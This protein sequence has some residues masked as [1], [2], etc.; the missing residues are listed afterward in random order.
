M[1]TITL[2]EASRARTAPT[3]PQRKNVTANGSFTKPITAPFHSLLRLK[4][5]LVPVDFSMP[6]KNALEYALPLIEQFGAKLTLMHVVEPGPLPAFA[7][8]FPPP[9]AKDDAADMCLNQLELLIK[10]NALDPKRVKTVVCRG[11]AAYEITSMARRLKA[12]LIIMSTHGCTG[13]KH[14]FLGSTAERVVRHAPCPV[15]VVRNQPPLLAGKNS[16]LKLDKILV[17]LDF[18]DCSLFALK[19][20]TALAREFHASQSLLHAVHPDYYFSNSDFDVINYAMLME[21]TR[22]AGLNQMKAL[23]KHRHF[24]GLNVSGEVHVGHPITEILNAAKR[25]DVDLIVL[26]THGRTGLKRVLLGSTAENVI[27]LASCPVLVV[28]KPEHEFVRG[29]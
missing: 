19:Y 18:S 14:T 2:K 11:R 28:R 3:A 12:D 10:Q 27:R 4:S 13:L 16:H 20:S 26:S 9:M 23:L 22:K 15:L 8:A 25:R 21:Y 17:P 6:S 7:T 24:A 5:I 29:N 1:K